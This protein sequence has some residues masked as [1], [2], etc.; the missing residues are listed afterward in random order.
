MKKSGTNYEEEK[1]AKGKRA[2]YMLSSTNKVLQNCYL[3]MKIQYNLIKKKTF[4]IEILRFSASRNLELEISR[5]DKNCKGCM[6]L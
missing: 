4:D 2:N 5:Q 3:F 6:F 1:E